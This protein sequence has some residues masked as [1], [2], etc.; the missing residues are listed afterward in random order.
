MT[1]SAAQV[2]A[3]YIRPLNDS[4]YIIH[5]TQTFPNILKENPINDDE[6]DLSYDVES[7]FTNVPVDTTIEYILNE[8]YV[9]KRLKPL[10]ESKLIMKRLLQIVYSQLMADFTKK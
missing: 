4:K 5:D 9:K 10:C 3:N 6:E 1:Y 7:L 2:V 8:I